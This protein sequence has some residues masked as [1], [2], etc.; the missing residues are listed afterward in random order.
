[1]KEYAATFYKSKAWANCRKTYAASVGGLCEDCLK[2]GL[3]TPGEIV[4][5]VIAITPENI[6]DPAVTLNWDNLRLV[7]RECHAVEHGAR[8][9]R[10]TVDALGR[11]SPRGL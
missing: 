5:H 4:H 7:C 8:I 10:Y 3:I 2:K 6:T 1:M 11:V 9:C